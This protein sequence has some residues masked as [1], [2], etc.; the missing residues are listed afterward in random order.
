MIANK[1]LILFSAMY[2]VTY[3]PRVLPILILTRMEI[4]DIIIRWLRYIPVAILAALL[5]PGILMVESRLTISY[6]NIFLLAALP[7]FL[8]AVYKKNIF[9]TVI[10]GMLA[11]LVFEHIL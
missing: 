6:D 11:V 5:A 9:L 3:I 1:Y 7:T 4:P 10:T 8:V 2:L